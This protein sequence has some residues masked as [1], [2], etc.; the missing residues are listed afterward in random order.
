VQPIVVL[1]LLWVLWFLAWLAVAIA[2]D[3][4]PHKVKGF[5]L[6]V[7]RLA[8][9][10][11]T[12]LLFTITPWPGLDVQYRLWERAPS[13]EMCWL[14]TAVAFAGFALAWWASL[15]RLA[16]GKRQDGV[17]DR[18]PYRYVRHPAHLGLVIAACATAAMFGRHSSSAGAVMLAAIFLARIL[19]EERALRDDEPAY[20]DYAERVP[21]LLPIPKRRHTAIPPVPA[22]QSSETALSARKAEPTVRLPPEITGPTPDNAPDLRVQ[23]VQLKLSLETMEK[24]EPPALTGADAKP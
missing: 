6:F 4:V 19:V 21:M 1:Y 16:A 13:E 18:G 20:D 5:F 14:L 3:A 17:V 2:G 7:Y 8:L 24:S 11:A 22:Q 15:S 9:L 23:P 10:G 12:L